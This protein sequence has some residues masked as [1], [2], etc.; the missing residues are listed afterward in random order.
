MDTDEMR[1]FTFLDAQPINFLELTLES[2]R[3]R[4]VPISEQF[5]SDIFRE[6]TPEVT[7]YMSPSP[8]QEISETQHFITET[9]RWMEIGNNLVF[10]ILSKQTEEFLGCCGLHGRGKIDK[11]ELGI[12]LKKSAHGHHYGREAIR[13]LVDWGWQHLDL[14]CMI[15]PVDRQNIPSAKIPQSLGGKPIEESKLETQNG[16]ILDLIV[17]QIARNKT[18]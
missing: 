8:P 14:D 12:W 18:D 16:E 13:T 5:A 17:Y 6:F 1:A 10:A 4:L 11:P 15:Y 2:E 7:K 3:L 9:R